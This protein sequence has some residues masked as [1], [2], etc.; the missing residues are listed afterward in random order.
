VLHGC[1]EFR[2][3]RS[4]EASDLAELLGHGRVNSIAIGGLKL[5]EGPGGQVSVCEVQVP[6]Y[7]S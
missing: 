1:E 5:S 7:W 4:D 6:M 2:L 3:E